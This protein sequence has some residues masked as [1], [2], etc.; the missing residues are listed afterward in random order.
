[1]NGVLTNLSNGI[2][3]KKSFF[4]GF[5]GS[6]GR[7][8]DISGK[9]AVNGQNNKSVDQ[10]QAMSGS[11]MITT[12]KSYN[13]MNGISN[14]NTS[15]IGMGTSHMNK[16]STLGNINNIRNQN[17]PSTVFQG[18]NVAKDE[19]GPGML[20]NNRSYSVNRALKDITNNVLNSSGA[21]VIQNQIANVK[22]K[23]GTSQN[24][25]KLPSDTLKQTRATGLSNSTSEQRG[26]GSMNM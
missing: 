11:S 17:Q 7:D 8:R 4:K 14:T 3:S 25:T 24:S 13:N 9:T 1:M 26:C 16:T 18:K 21:A 20:P 6:R 5:L 15:M 2:A 22:T 19:N 10:P 12:N 23:M